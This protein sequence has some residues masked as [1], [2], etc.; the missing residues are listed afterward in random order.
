MSIIKTQDQFDEIA[1]HVDGLT[2]HR[3]RNHW[4]AI[5]YLVKEVERL[6]TAKSEAE[7]AGRNLLDQFAKLPDE[8]DGL[9]FRYSDGEIECQAMR[10]TESPKSEAE[11]VVAAGVQWR[12]YEV[13]AAA[14]L[15]GMR[16]GEGHERRVDN[17]LREL[18]CAID[19]YHRTLTAAVTAKEEKKDRAN[20]PWC[21]SRLKEPLSDYYECGTFI[22][23]AVPRPSECHQ[24][25]K[26]N[27][28][29]TAKEEP[30]NPHDEFT[31]G[32][33]QVEAKEE[34]EPSLLDEEIFF[35]KPARKIFAIA[36]PCSNCG[37]DHWRP[38]C[39][40]IREEAESEPE[41]FLTP[42]HP[43]DCGCESCVKASIEMY[44]EVESESEA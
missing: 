10:Q 33:Q 38:D 36:G 18:R 4:E 6:Q 8:Y 11:R 39:P 13:D 23:Q 24:R 27:L 14:K 12:T 35:G 15:L 32:L 16:D 5:D 41:E 42:G 20:C 22:W 28:A 19:D 2:G 3:P 31:K 26:N 37:G 21:G 29:V 17:S 44:P 43:E 40:T 7:R 30:I 25:E 1:D 34:A 9:F